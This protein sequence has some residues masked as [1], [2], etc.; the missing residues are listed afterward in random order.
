MLRYA[1]IFFVIVIVAAI[2]A[3]GGIG[4]SF[5]FTAKIVF[6]IALPFF[7]ISSLFVG[8]LYKKHLPVNKRLPDA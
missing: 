3:F 2:L 1:I 4:F 7:V 8:I 6:F 5:P